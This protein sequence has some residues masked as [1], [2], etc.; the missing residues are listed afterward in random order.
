MSWFEYVPSLPGKCEVC[1]MHE[2]CR[3]DTDEKPPGCEAGD[4]DKRTGR[5]ETIKKHG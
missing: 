1:G 4:D 5:T 2:W 3:R